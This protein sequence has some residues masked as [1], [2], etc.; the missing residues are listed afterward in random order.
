MSQ[1]Y[2]MGT[3][4]KVFLSLTGILLT[5]GII[6]IVVAV[7]A[8]NKSHAEEIT[9]QAPIPPPTTTGHQVPETPVAAQSTDAINPSIIAIPEAQATAPQQAEEEKQKSQAEGDEVDKQ[10]N[11]Q[12]QKME[13]QQ[14]VQTTAQST[15]ATAQMPATTAALPSPMDAPDIPPIL[16]QRANPRQ[17]HIVNKNLLPP[18]LRDSDIRVSVKVHVNAQGRPSKVILDKGV[19][20]AFGYNDAA[21]QAAYESTYTPATRGGKPINGWV[22]V[23]FNFGRAK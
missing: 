13:T 21:K 23:E 20:G 1:K 3:G 22:T 12:H 11:L 6:G 5:A 17:P 19:D 2:R 16:T 8:R 4:E 7:A 18:A 9:A 15:L 14:P 10:A